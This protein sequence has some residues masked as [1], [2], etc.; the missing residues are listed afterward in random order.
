MYS[1]L[2]AYKVGEQSPSAWL[3]RLPCSFVVGGDVQCPT[4]NAR[5]VRSVHGPL[6]KS[7]PATFVLLTLHPITWSLACALSAHFLDVYFIVSLV[8]ALASGSRPH[9][10]LQ[11]TLQRERDCSS[12]L[13]TRLKK[14]TPGRGRRADARAERCPAASADP[15]IG[16]LGGAG[17][18]AAADNQRIDR[19]H[20][21]P[22]TSSTSN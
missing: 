16:E 5:G 11:Y 7:D 14:S 12:W 21:Q 3:V 13:N 22:H 8:L 4:V 10:A 19:A 17:L 18:V 15:T 2:A 9:R 6:A 20:T 1:V